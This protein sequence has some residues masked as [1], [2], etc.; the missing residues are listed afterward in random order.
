MFPGIR[1][2]VCLSFLILSMGFQ[3]YGASLNPKPVRPPSEG[4]HRKEGIN[5]IVNELRTYPE[6]S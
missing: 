6:K 5:E 3:V 2:L 4:S 1:Q